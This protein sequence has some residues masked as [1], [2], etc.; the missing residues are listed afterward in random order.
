MV[1]SQLGI[2]ELNMCHESWVLGNGQVRTSGNLATNSE[3][4]FKIETFNAHTQG[5]ALLIDGQ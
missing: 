1:I 4:G 5:R 2:N 3:K